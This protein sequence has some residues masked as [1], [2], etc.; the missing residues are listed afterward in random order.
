MDPPPRTRLELRPSR[1]DC[2]LTS[3]ACV[4]TAALLAA[5]P[6]PWLAQG[7]GAAAVLA[8]LAHGLRRATGRG[9]PLSI[10][11]GIDRTLVVTDRRGRSRAGSIRDASY[12]G[13]WVTTIVWR[14]AAAPWWHPASTLLV[15]PDM[16]PPDEFRRLRVVLRY[17]WP[18]AGGASSGVDAG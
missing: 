6:L 8:V 11:V 3:L 12:V 15:L 5:L 2:A 1:I 17:G 18:L 9:I 14:A 16:L 7:A 10:E 13:A 4:A